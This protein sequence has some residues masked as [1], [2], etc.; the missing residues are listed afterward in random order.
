[1]EYILNLC[2]I[3][4][5]FYS[6]CYKILQI[7]ADFQSFQI[8]IK[9]CNTLSNILEAILDLNNK[10]TK[11]FSSQ[12]SLYIFLRICYINNTKFLIGCD[13]IQ[14]AQFILPIINYKIQIFIT[15]MVAITYWHT[16]LSLISKTIGFSYQF[17]QQI[18]EL[19]QISL[20]N[21][22]NL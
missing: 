12:Y 1:M 10:I 15:I 2:F 6:F 3:L 16:P 19:T 20:S 18:W 21:Q 8:L 7:K 22:T 14:K 11:F 17:L 9:I 4:T 5:S 13:M